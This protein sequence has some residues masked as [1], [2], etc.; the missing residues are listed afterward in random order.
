MRTT[1]IHLVRFAALTL[2]MAAFAWNNCLASTTSVGVAGHAANYAT[3]K[4]GPNMPPDPWDGGGT[5]VTT[6]A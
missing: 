5:G 6:R 2:L 3:A 4:T 1:Q